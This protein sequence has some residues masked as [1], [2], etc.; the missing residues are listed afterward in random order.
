MRLRVILT[1]VVRDSDVKN[2][3]TVEY[4]QP[5]LLSDK[6]L[7][8]NHLKTK[9]VCVQENRV[10]VS[11]N[12]KRNHGYYPHRH[13]FLLVDYIEDYEPGEF[14]VGYKCVTYDEYFSVDIFHRSR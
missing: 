8:S 13:P 14:A 4:G 9:Y 7:R 11:V 1:G 12:N 2:G 3:Q 10:Y 6:Y 5:F